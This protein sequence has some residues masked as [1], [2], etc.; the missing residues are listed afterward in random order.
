MKASIAPASSNLMYVGRYRRDGTPLITYR[1]EG[2]DDEIKFATPSW[3]WPFSRYFAKRVEE[4]R[5]VIGSSLK[6]GAGR[7][8]LHD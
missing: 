6:I 3:V 4:N 5:P 2:G 7:G 8:V 1:R